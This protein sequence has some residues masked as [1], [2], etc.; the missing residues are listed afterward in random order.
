MW[1]CCLLLSSSVLL[2]CSAREAEKDI[3]SSPSA[4]TSIVQ[5]CCYRQS[6]DNTLRMKPMFVNA[7]LMLGLVWLSASIADTQI[8]GREEAKKTSGVRCRLGRLEML[9][10]VLFSS[11]QLQRH[12]SRLARR[13][14]IRETFSLFAENAFGIS[15][16]QP[17]VAIESGKETER[18][19]NIIWP[20]HLFE[21]IIAVQG[22]VERET[23]CSSS[24]D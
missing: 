10:Y 5:L 22:T 19:E 11:K 8:W 14:D 9:C 23:H 16:C 15:I 4:S 2:L 13:E 12:A 1:N 24:L 18:N 21:V 20:S 3:S 7:H 17:F 6:Y